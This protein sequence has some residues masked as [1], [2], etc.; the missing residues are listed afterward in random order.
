MMKS[1]ERVFLAFSMFGI[2]FLT[3]FD[4]ITDLEEGVTWW[5]VSIEGVIALIAGF[6]FLYLLK[7]S[8]LLKRSIENERKITGQLKEENKKFKKQSKSYLE[9][10]SST[11]DLQL[12]QWELSKSEKEV[13]FLLIKGFSLK[14]I[15]EVRG[16][17]EK[18]ARAQ[19]TAIYDKSKLKGRAQLTAYF[20][21]D[22]L[23]PINKEN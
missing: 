6:S 14:E 5:H 17:K 16:T 11:I 3:L 7:S 18:T 21:E 23:L 4:L 1:N 12:T 10:L 19:S 22:L 15:A 2:S 20:L 9:G 8:F 13:A